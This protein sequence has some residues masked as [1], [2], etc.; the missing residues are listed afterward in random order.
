MNHILH[1]QYRCTID[2]VEY[3]AYIKV[4]ARYNSFSIINRLCI[5]DDYD[6]HL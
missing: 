4:I 5:N 2:A 3:I 1:E 6:Q